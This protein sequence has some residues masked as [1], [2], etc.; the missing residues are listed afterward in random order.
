G[1]TGAR[2]IGM[3]PVSISM[4]EG[5]GDGGIVRFVRRNARDVDVPLL[6]VGQNRE[7]IRQIQSRI[8]AALRFTSQDT[9]PRLQY[10]LLN[11]ALYEV[12][13]AYVTGAQTQL[14]IEQGGDTYCRWLLTLRAPQ[15]YW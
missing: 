4:I 3:P 15:P 6:L 5:A 2:G 10:R 8:A 1:L 7:E 14:G 13:V 12:R 9:M 11:G